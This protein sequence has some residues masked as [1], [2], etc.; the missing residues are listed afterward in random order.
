M[1]A[2]ATI[3]L[4]PIAARALEKPCG[5]GETIYMAPHP[6]TGNA[7]PF[8]VNVEG[9]LAPTQTTPGLGVSHF[10]NC[11]KAASYRRRP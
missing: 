7:H 1:T 3:K 5:C 4:L 6:T 8:S 9:G 10:S 2:P 11:P